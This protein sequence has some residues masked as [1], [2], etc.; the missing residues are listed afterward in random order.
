MDTQWRIELLGGARVTQGGQHLPPFRR[1]RV[2][3]LFVYLG[4][5]AGRSHLREELIEL[6]WP[7]V[8]PDVGRNNLRVTLHL[9]R[10]H[11]KEA[12]PPADR[13]LLAAG[14]A[15]QLRPAACTTDVAE[16]EA[17]LQASREAGTHERTRRLA[18]ATALYRGELL[19]GFFEPWVLAERGRLGELYQH[20]LQQLVGALEQAGDPEGA[21]EYAR[22]AVSVDPLREEAHYDLMR[23]HAAAGRPGAALRQYEELERLLQQEL[24]E[25]PSAATR[26]LAEELRERGRIVIAARSAL[27]E[28]AASEG[29]VAPEAPFP[30]PAPLPA[31]PEHP[32]PGTRLPPQFTR[33][34]GREEEISRLTE[35]LCVAETRLVTLTGPGGSGKT[36][37]AIAVAGRLEE[38]FAGRRADPSWVSEPNNGPWF[39]PLAEVTEPHS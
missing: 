25:I 35:L 15:I 31:A 27:P 36:R 9:L 12:D 20:A 2:A 8:D 38:A 26:A 30:S 10:Q 19:P 33:F 37:L 3:S 24:E 34:F 4:F 23:L 32:L 14:D 1:P 29:P 7:E 22:R 39:V 17:A 13:L 6:L 18:D 5:Y 16:F 21:L 11:L 28:S